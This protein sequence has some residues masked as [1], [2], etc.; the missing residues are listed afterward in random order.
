MA[1]L[2]QL[3]QQL[4]SLKLS[5]TLENLELRLMEAAQKM[6]DTAKVQLF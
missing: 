3:K 1:N 6:P 4:K 2:A 5:G